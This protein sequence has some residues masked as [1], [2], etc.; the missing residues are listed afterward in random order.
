MTRRAVAGCYYCL[1]V[2]PLTAIKK[3]VDDGETPLCP[4]CG[5]D[6]VLD[7]VNCGAV[8]RRYHNKKFG[9]QK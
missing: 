5:I 8:L 3:Y 7:G 6:A 2:F 9:V 1:K 4:Y